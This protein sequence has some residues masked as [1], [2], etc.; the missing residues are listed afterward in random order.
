MVISMY[1]PESLKVNTHTN[2]KKEKVSCGVQMHDWQWE[3]FLT[4]VSSHF[5]NSQTHYGEIFIFL[6]KFLEITFTFWL[7][8]CRTG[9][10]SFG[11]SIYLEYLTLRENFYFLCKWFCIFILTTFMKSFLRCLWMRAVF[12]WFGTHCLFL[13]RQ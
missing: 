4:F 12:T 6:G 2:N 11:A 9:K 8:F 5:R 3:P 10:L 13:F 1:Y 7:A